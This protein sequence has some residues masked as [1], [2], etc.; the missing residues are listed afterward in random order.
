M[1]NGRELNKQV[2]TLTLHVA[3]QWELV[4]TG[5]RRN[6]AI[7][8]CSKS[9]RRFMNSQQSDTAAVYY[10]PTGVSCKNHTVRIM[11]QYNEMSDVWHKEKRPR[12]SH[13]PI[14]R[15]GT[16][17]ILYILY[18]FIYIICILHGDRGGT[19]FKVPCYKSEGRWFDSKWRNSNFSLT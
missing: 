16:I 5:G 8:I 18:I 1:Q 19:V 9:V 17:H 6:G 2:A 11:T 14:Y 3:A 7:V 13:R 15:V 12:P 10:V 4:L